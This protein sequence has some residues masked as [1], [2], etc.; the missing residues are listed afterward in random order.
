MDIQLR[1]ELLD[2]GLLP[3]RLDDIAQAEYKSIGIDASKF[4]THYSPSKPDDMIERGR[5][6]RE[7]K[8]IDKVEILYDMEHSGQSATEE[9]DGIVEQIREDLKYHQMVSHREKI[10][11]HWYGGASNGAVTGIVGVNRDPWGPEFF[12]NE[13]IF[14]SGHDGIAG[15][16]FSSN[17]DIPDNIISSKIFD[18]N[19]DRTFNSNNIFNFYKN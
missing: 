1:F 11:K 8:I 14:K 2:L 4:E 3:I 16:T 18:S 12:R 6:E 15:R 5:K 7:C 9:Y 13:S 10:L 19:N 17:D